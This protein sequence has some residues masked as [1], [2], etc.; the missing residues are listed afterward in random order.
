MKKL[1]KIFVIFI[2]IIIGIIFW[3]YSQTKSLKVKEY[4]IVDKAIPDSFNGFKIIHFGDVLFGSSVDDNYLNKVVKEINNYKPD[5]VIFTGDLFSKESNLTKKNKEDIIK[6]LGNIKVSLAK[7]AIYGD[8][9]QE[10]YEDIM[11]KSGFIIL[12]DNYEEVYFNSVTPI[13]ISNTDIETELF[14]IRLLHKPDDIDA[15]NKDNVNVILAGHSLNGQIRLP[16]YGAL[17]K[18]NGSKKYTDDYY[19]YDDYKVFITSGLGTY[20]PNLR[21]LN[22]PSIN[23]YRLTNY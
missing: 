11:S 10:E 7:Y 21:L 6:S 9:D 14:N 3:G 15:I 5:I 17:M 19:S 1:I 4:N 13:I 8:N 18:K 2:F 12:K 23:L 22:P 20:S 16:F